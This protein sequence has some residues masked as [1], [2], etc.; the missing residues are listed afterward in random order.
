MVKKKPAIFLDRD[1]VLNIPKIKRRKSFAPTKVSEFK[2]YPFVSDLCNKL[3]K[4]YL[5]IVVTNQPDLKKGK[6]KINQ[7]NLMHIKLKK[8]INYD[9]LYY[10]SSLSINSKFKKPNA[11]ML[12]KSIK[13]FNIDTRM[14]YLIG[15]RWSDIEAGK[16][17]KC[18]T[19]FIDRNYEEKKPNNPDFTV[20]S[21]K[22][23]V[24][25]IFN[26]KYQKNKN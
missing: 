8:K 25:V 1:G 13:E 5:L 3:K 19:I 18:K 21:F 6:L 23:A 20:K 16:K 12:L 11:G 24:E 14:S 9:Q 7:L 17:V 22:K 26:D 15:D 4:N 10:C 2:L